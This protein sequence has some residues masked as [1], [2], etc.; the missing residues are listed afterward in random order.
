[1]KASDPIACFPRLAFPLPRFCFAVPCL[2]WFLA[3]GPTTRGAPIDSSLANFTSQLPVVVLDTQGTG[4]LNANDPAR[5]VRFDLFAAAGEGAPRPGT[6]AAGPLFSSAAAARVRG[7]SSAVFPKKSYSIQLLDDRGRPDPRA[8]LGLAVDDTWNLISPWNYDRTFLHNAYVYSLS[9]SLGRWA[10]HTKFVEVFTRGDAAPLTA[11]LTAAHDTGISLLTERITI[12]REH[13]NLTPLSGADLTGGYLLKI[14]SPE[15][16]DFTFTTPHLVEWGPPS[17]LIVHRPN[18]DDLSAAQR[19]YIRDYVNTMEG[20]LYADAAAN[21]TTHRHL[22]YLDRAS[23]VDYH[24][25]QV[26]AGNVEAFQRSFF[27]TKDRGGKLVAGPQGDFDRALGSADHR[28][29]AWDQ[30]NSPDATD[31]WHY[32]WWGLL[33]RDPDFMQAWIDRWQALRRSELSAEKLSSL[34]DRL[35]A[36]IGSAAAARDAARWPDDAGH[37]ADGTWAG[38]IAQMKSWVTQRAAWI[39]AKFVAPPQLETDGVLLCATAP[40][41]ARLIYTVDGSDPRGPNGQVALTARVATA[42]VV[43]DASAL[44]C[45][46]AWNPTAL[47]F[48]G[49]AWSGPLTRAEA[50]PITAD[51]NPAFQSRLANLSTFVHLS[52]GSGAPLTGLVVTGD[53]AKQIL[54]RAVGPG[55]RQF[56]LTATLADPVLSILNGRG[57]E[58]A[59][60]TGWTLGPDALD[61]PR[62]STSAGA[63]RLPAA[64]ADS[65]LVLRLAPG[66]YTVVVSSASDS[67]GMALAEI[68]ELDRV[69]SLANLSTCAMVYAR[70][71][72]LAGGFV[73][74][75]SAP[76]KFLVRAVGPTLAAWGVTDVL[77]DPVITIAAATGLIAR[78]DDWGSAATADAPENSSGD[79]T[80]IAVAATACGA[81]A[82]PAGSLDAALVVTLA[83]GAYTA[84]VTGKNGASGLVLLEVYGVP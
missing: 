9:R 28:N 52:P 20:A 10:P 43:V 15:P 80:A 13:V 54:V 57:V 56:G 30:W 38:E 40:A 6:F 73:V 49:S 78:N 42:P 51:A 83:P 67:T 26:L 74:R 79:S 61:L 48:P 44:L 72:L 2:G 3:L 46:R 60:N 33:T 47:A 34:A 59:R 21:W 5:P 7:S 19:N 1:M 24:L 25:L 69:G 65:A 29:R 22:L 55:L 16:G 14:D 18:A 71:P 66:S 27:F 39:D 4:P 45:I 76:K 84:Q 50:R 36:E 64:S 11:P 23:W 8:L 31:L 12:D 41:G 82:L 77:A 81:F 63:F 53:T 37:F 32:G 17:S 68:Y 35:A 70:A 58:I 75:G 62:L